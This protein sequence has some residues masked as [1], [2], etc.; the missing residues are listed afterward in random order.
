ML[1][2]LVIALLTGGLGFL[3]GIFAWWS[4]SAIPG[5]GLRLFFPPLAGHGRHMFRIRPM[6]A[7]RHCRC[8]GF[9]RSFGLKFFQRGAE[10]VQIVTVIAYA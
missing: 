3:T 6:A 4:L 9:D 5:F 10:L 8:S 1:Q 7:G 2:R